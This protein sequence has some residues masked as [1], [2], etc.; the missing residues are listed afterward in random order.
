[1]IYSFPFFIY[2]LISQGR[3]TGSVPLHFSEVDAIIAQDRFPD[4]S[5]ISSAS[6]ERYTKAVSK[7]NT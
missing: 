5:K 4:Q 3:I 1:M 2:F 6:K 7:K